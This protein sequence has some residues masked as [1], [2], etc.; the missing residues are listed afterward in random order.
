[1]GFQ[2]RVKKQTAV[3]LEP[4]ASAGGVVASYNCVDQGQLQHWVWT[5]KAGEPG[6][7]LLMNVG[8]GKMT[9][10]FSLT[11]REKKKMPYPSEWEG[12]PPET[13]LELLYINPSGTEF[14]W[15]P[16]S[17]RTTISGTNDNKTQYELNVAV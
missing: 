9:A 16:L 6:A 8:N 14:P 3:K 11:A 1:M 12:L 13:Y 2:D 15:G 5:V 4:V 7:G 10:T 17:L